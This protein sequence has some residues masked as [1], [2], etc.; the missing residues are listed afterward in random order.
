MWYLCYISKRLA[1]NSKNATVSPE[2]I[3]TSVINES[4]PSTWD[5]RLLFD[6]ERRSPNQVGRE[7][8]V[9]CVAFDWRCRDTVEKTKERRTYHCFQP[10]CDCICATRETAEWVFATVG[11]SGPV[12]ILIL[13]KKKRIQRTE[14]TGWPTFQSTWREVSYT[15]FFLSH[16][17]H[18]FCTGNEN[19][20]CRSSWCLPTWR[21]VGCTFFFGV[22][23]FF[24]PLFILEFT[25]RWRAFKLKRN[26]APTCALTSRSSSYP[27][28]AFS[29]F[30]YLLFMAQL[31]AEFVFTFTPVL[32]S[33]VAGNPSCKMYFYL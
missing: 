1:P 9:T 31:T 21:N 15:F 29:F 10:L 16:L 6:E 7:E 22:K 17:L 33:E 20:S 5:V 26:T 4:P 23:I 18:F 30:I 25:S 24:A 2:R 19:N 27:C 14:V 8:V 13:K 3:C 32:H 28:F 11:S 12:D